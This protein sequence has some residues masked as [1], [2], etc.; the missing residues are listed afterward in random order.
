MESV[1]RPRTALALATAACAFAPAVA[2]AP[3]AL[4]AAPPPAQLTGF[5]CQT[6]RSAPNR[7][8]STT[9]VM[10]PRPGTQHMWLKFELLRRTAAS[11]RYV[12]VRGGRHSDLGKWVS[13]PDPTLGQQPGD[14][15]QLAKPVVDLSAPARYRFRVWFRWQLAKTQV[16]TVLLSAVCR[17]S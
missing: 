13:P 12:A 7:E 17:Q 4:A 16:Q 15:W 10:R 9:A 3:P 14:I 1:R 5:V 2:A 6:A 11:P 8:V